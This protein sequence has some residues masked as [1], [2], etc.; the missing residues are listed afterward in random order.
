VF[1]NSRECA[2][3]LGPPSDGFAWRFTVV[4]GGQLRDGTAH[5]PD[6]VLLQQMEGLLTSAWHAVGVVNIAQTSVGGERIL[7][8]AGLPQQ[9]LYGA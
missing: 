3:R 9:V 7:T 4:E 5:V 8:D 6:A 2:D 1:R